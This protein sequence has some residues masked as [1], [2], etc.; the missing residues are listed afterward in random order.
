MQ[1]I[2]FLVSLKLVTY[3]LFFNNMVYFL[4]LAYY[5]IVTFVLLHNYS[6]YIYD[7]NIL[8]MAHG[9]LS[10]V[11]SGLRKYSATQ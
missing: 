4:P 7:S 6:L 3:N 11:I 9:I 8:S 5:L 1:K 10:N 2:Y